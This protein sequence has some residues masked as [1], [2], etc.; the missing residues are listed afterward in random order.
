MFSKTQISHLYCILVVIHIEYTQNPVI[1]SN[2]FNY[3]NYEQTI[4]LSENTQVLKKEH[5][6]R[7]F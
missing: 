7:S 3:R 4:P 6:K 5:T 1:T 2:R